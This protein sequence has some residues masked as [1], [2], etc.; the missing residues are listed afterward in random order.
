MRPGFDPWIGKAPWRRERLPTA[1][2]CPGEPHGPHRLSDFHSHVRVCA[3][4]RTAAHQAPLST[5]FSRQEYWSGLPCPP[6][7]DLPNPGTEPTSLMSPALAGGF[8]TTSA[9]WEAPFKEVMRVKSGHTGEALMQYERCLYKR[10]QH[11]SL[12]HAKDKSRH[13]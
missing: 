2:F 13:I 6:T 1:V 7:G 10:K 3:F 9:T 4:L 12:G 5:G 11:R 8:F